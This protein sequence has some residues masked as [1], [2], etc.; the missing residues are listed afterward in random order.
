V[1]LSNGECRRGQNQTPFRS[2]G[3]PLTRA[4]AA[5]LTWSGASL[6]I[7]VEQPIVNR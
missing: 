6:L 5:D 3:A 7:G 1:A 2:G 4:S